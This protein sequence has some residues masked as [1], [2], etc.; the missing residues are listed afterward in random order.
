M[1][2]VEEEANCEKWCKNKSTTRNCALAKGA[3]KVRRYVKRKLHILRNKNK[4]SIQHYGLAYEQI[5]QW[6]APVNFVSHPATG[7]ARL[8]VVS[9]PATGLARLNVVSHPATAHAQLNV[10]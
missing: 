10:L 8:N 5:I 6:D 2:L 9:H 7:L 3:R 4:H 1:K